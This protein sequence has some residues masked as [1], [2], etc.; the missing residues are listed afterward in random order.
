[1]WCG[2]HCAKE[3]RM[4][5]NSPKQNLLKKHK[6]GWVFFEKILYIFYEYSSNT[7]NA[8]W[9][10]TS[11]CSAPPQHTHT[12]MLPHI[13]ICLDHW[14]GNTNRHSNL[15]FH[16]YFH[17]LHQEIDCCHGQYGLWDGKNVSWIPPLDVHV[18]MSNIKLPFSYNRFQYWSHPFLLEK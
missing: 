12:H 4:D 7:C 10:C 5:Y 8:P 16:Y 18:H 15:V 11:L 14:V 3:D 6:I 2:L 17:Y 13:Y 1:M 9:I